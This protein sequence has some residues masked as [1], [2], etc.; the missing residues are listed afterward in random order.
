VEG[1]LDPAT[2]EDVAVFPT[3][4]D[5]NGK[6]YWWSMMKLEGKERSRIRSLNWK[7]VKLRLL[8]VLSS[9]PPTY[10]HITISR[11]SPIASLYFSSH[12]IT[13]AILVFLYRNTVTAYTILSAKSVA[14]LASQAPGL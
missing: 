8:H 14:N 9:R 2:D 13:S 3:R 5:E 4:R 11:T 6:S 1:Q 10:L 12:V 7:D